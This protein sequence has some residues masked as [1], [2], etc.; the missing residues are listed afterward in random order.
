M[1]ERV[2]I[3]LSVAILSHI[4]VSIHFISNV[5][6]QFLQLHLVKK[7]K[8]L[9]SHWIEEQPVGSF[10]GRFWFVFKVCHLDGVPGKRGTVFPHGAI[11]LVILISVKVHNVFLIPRPLFLFPPCPSVAKPCTR[12][13]CGDTSVVILAIHDWGW[14][15]GEFIRGGSSSTSDS[16]ST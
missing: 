3:A 10:S 11:N 6:K 13:R 8:W 4:M 16:A 2:L 14:G 12:R 7:V 1:K 15:G 9:K 5:V